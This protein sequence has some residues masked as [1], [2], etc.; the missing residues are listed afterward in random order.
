MTPGL[1]TRWS[2][3]T[4]IIA[5]LLAVIILVGGFIAWAMMSQISGAVVASGQVEV[6][7]QRQIVQPPVLLQ[8]T[9]QLQP[10]TPSP[11]RQ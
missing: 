10:H 9:S 4:P 8:C 3:R 5:G 11:Q 7:Q 6:E 1:D 2:V